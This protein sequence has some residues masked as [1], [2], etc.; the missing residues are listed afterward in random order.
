V[1]TQHTPG[2][3]IVVNED[4]G[5]VIRGA[6][7]EREERGIKYSFRDYVGSTW[8]HRSDTGD[9]NACLIAA[10]PDLLE[11]LKR[12]LKHIKWEAASADEV[13]AGCRE[14]IAQA[15]AAIAKA[16]GSAS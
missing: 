6:E 5:Q 16:T 11:A 2:P 9:A 1:S 8:G 3:W 12:T 15:E 4:Y 7:V 14:D 13:T 10:A